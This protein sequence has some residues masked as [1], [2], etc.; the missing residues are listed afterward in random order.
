MWWAYNNNLTD[1]SII[2]PILE[3]NSRYIQC[4]HNDCRKVYGYFD[5]ISKIIVVNLLVI[6]CGVAQY[7]GYSSVY[8][9]TLLRSKNYGDPVVHEDFLV[10][11]NWN[12][13]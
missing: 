12:V 9:Y 10:R 2:L 11:L 7:R 3:N 1:E 13:V 5:L 6:E 8:Y 4:T